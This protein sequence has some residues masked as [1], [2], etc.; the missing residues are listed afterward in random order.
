MSKNYF[1][2][3]NYIGTGEDK[4]HLRRQLS[5]CDF[6]DASTKFINHQIKLIDNEL[7]SIVVEASRQADFYHMTVKLSLDD[8]EGRE[9]VCRIGTRVRFRNGTFT[10]EWFRNRYLD[11]GEG[12]PKQVYS[13]YL[14]KGKGFSYPLG[15]FKN[16]PHWVREL[17]SITEFEYARLRERAALL[18][19]MRTAIKV[20]ERLFNR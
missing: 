10:A 4:N 19:K 7:F 3:E 14:R 6:S 20:Y 17:V 9:S 13:T 1:S 8:Y 5:T 16:E 15:Q 12:I 18:T 2:F 11:K